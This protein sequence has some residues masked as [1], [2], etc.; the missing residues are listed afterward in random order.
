MTTTRHFVDA[1]AITRG[2]RHHF[3]G[4]YDKCCWDA[5]GRWILGMETDFMDHPPTAEEAATIGLIDTANGNAW[6]PL[7]ETRAWNWQQGCML[8]WVGESRSI[9]FNDRRD[10]RFV[11]RILDTETGAERVLDRPI[12]TITGDGRTA[13]S[14]N[15][16]RLQHQRPGYGYPG[17]P[18]AWESMPE[19]EDDGL[20]VIDVA[21]GKSR[22]VATVAQVAAFQRLPEFDGKIH[23][24]NHVQFNRSGDRIGFLHRWKSPDEEVGET[25]LMTVS[26][27]GGRLRVVSDHGLF[28]HYDWLGDDRI[29]GWAHRRGL[30]DHYYLFGEGDG[31]V[32]PVGTE[33]L[34]CDGH[35]NFGPHRDWFLTDTYPDAEDRR[36]L[37]LFHLPSGRRIDI[38]RFLSPPTAE[39]Q[40]RCD[41]HPRWSRD[42]RLICIDSLHEGSRQM[43]VLDVGGV[44]AS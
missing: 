7:A 1:V 31:S 13:V 26:P 2:P 42:G 30:G 8:Q 27:D 22:L 43:Y 14:L 37:L 32:V 29:L 33:A 39:W 25:R 9:I 17:V 15:F 21:T 20:H 38:G 19:P 34:N 36:T 5:G 41:L 44:M 16:S 24:F 11:A 28:S 6:K 3:F 40:I 4:Y 23:R 18:D 35:C 10:G 12:Y